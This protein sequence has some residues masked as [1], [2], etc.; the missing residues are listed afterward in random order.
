MKTTLLFAIGLLAA[1]IAHADPQHIVIQPGSTV[2]IEPYAYTTVTC[3]GAPA[4]TKTIIQRSCECEPKNSSQ[5]D[6]TNSLVLVLLMSDGTVQKTSLGEF[7]YR[8]KCDSARAAN[9]LCTA[10]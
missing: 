5:T 3:D 1:G 8:T 9:S 4:N 10:N 7:D 2:T 6:F